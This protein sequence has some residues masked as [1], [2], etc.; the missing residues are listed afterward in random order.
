VQILTQARRFSDAK[1]WSF[2]A[3]IG[4]ASAS[5]LGMVAAFGTAPSTAEIAPIMRPVVEELARPTTEPVES[6][7]DLFVREERIQRGDTVATQ[8]AR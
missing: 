4:V 5:L 2:W 3:L 7:S 1:P 8:M 6:A